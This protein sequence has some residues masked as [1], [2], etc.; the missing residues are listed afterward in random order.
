LA[1]IVQFAGWIYRVWST[2][3]EDQARIVVLLEG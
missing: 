3:I 1:Y 2:S